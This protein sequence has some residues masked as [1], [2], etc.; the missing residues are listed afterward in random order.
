VKTISCSEPK[1][2]MYK[3]KISDMVIYH[4]HNSGR[5]CAR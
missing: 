3:G 2:L 5:L 1:E 4:R